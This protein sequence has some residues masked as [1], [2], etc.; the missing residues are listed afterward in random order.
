VASY[1]EFE[2]L[3]GTD[4]HGNLS[5]CRNCVSGDYLAC[6]SAF[7]SW[8]VANQH[9]VLAVNERDNAMNV[10]AVVVGSNRGADATTETEEEEDRRDI[11]PNDNE[12]DRN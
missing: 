2:L 8:A 1:S 3:L 10:A 9:G 7:A 5:L 4:D 6:G 11:D 12:N